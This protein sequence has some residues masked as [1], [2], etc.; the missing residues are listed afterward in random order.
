MLRRGGG[1][2]EV[3]AM[4]RVR[5]KQAPR[6]PRSR[7]LSE[8]GSCEHRAGGRCVFCTWAEDGRQ[9]WGGLSAERG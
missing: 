7:S 3:L 9:G 8:G 5:D 6:P 1:V 2:L 4:R